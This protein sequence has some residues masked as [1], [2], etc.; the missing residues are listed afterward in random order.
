M[1]HHI[2][3]GG[4]LDGATHSMY[5]K[6]ESSGTGNVQH[7]TRRRK[8]GQRM[9]KRKKEEIAQ[10]MKNLCKTKRIKS[11]RKQKI[12]KRDKNHPT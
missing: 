10:S 5:R 4:N 8:K 2:R 9:E 1:N 3:A 6:T 7:R 11:F 12:W